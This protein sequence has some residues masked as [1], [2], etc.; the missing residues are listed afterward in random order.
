MIGKGNRPDF[1]EQFG[2]GILI[3]KNLNTQFLKKNMLRSYPDFF[4]RLSNVN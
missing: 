1:F 3:F 2:T 4:S